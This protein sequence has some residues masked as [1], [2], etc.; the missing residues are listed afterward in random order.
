ME[1]TKDWKIEVDLDKKLIFPTVITSTQQRPDVVLW[2]PSNKAVIIIELTVPWETRV[3]EAHERKRAK[4]EQLQAD[5]VQE[6]W[7]SWSFPIEITARG[8]PT[9]SVWRLATALGLKGREKKELAKDLAE[10]AERASCWL[11]LKS[12][13]KVW[14]R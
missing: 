7:K 3:Q 14:S 10:Q 5:C 9:S 13:E 11:W 12:S 8:F 1:I 2:S 4:Y 6:G